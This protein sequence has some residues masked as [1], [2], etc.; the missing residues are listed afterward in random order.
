MNGGIDVFGLVGTV[1]G[2][3]EAG[4]GDVFQDLLQGLSVLLIKRKQEKRHHHRDHQ[5]HAQAAGQ[6]ALGE[7]IQRDANRRAATKA[8]DLALGEAKGQFGFDLVQI[9]RHVGID[10]IVHRF[11]LP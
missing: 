2:P 9:L 5:G 10:H 4:R 3:L 6:L 1:L 11:I 7:K 8:D